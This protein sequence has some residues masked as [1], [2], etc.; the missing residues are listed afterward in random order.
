MHL[1]LYVVR[2]ML[3]ERLYMQLV[4]SVWEVRILG[5]LRNFISAWLNILLLCGL[6]TYLKSQ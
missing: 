2:T 5:R 4:L 6:E 1:K 3:H